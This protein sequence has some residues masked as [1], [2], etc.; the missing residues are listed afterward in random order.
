[1]INSWHK[2]ILQAKQ[3]YYVI[4]VKKSIILH[5]IKQI[6]KYYGTTSEQIPP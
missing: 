6:V 4:G 1:M 5:K 2:H 3:F